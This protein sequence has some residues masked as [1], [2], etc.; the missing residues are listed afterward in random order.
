MDDRVQPGDT[1]SAIS[2]RVHISARIIARLNHVS[3]PNHIM[4]GQFLKMPIFSSH[5]R[6][7]EH[8]T[9]R[10]SPTLKAAGT[11]FPSDRTI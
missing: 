2:K 10:V 11:A 8:S 4:A 3:H 6:G 5:R 7:N 9:H 1:L